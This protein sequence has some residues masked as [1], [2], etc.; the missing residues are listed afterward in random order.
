MRGA[1]LLAQTLSGAGTNRI[2]AL[3]GNQIMP[4]FDAC[5]DAGIKITHTRHEAAAVFMAEAY[6]QLTGEIGVV[7]VTAGGGLANTAGA[8]FSASESNTPVLLLSGDSP[9]AQDGRGAFQEL[10]Q[11]AITSAITKLSFRSMVAKDLGW[12]TARA[13]RAARS[14]RPG[15]VHIALPFDVLCEDVGSA[16][17]PEKDAFAQDAFAASNAAL[18]EVRERLAKSRRPLVLLGPAL[19]ATRAPALHATLTQALDA[20]VFAMESPRGLNDPSLGNL[21]E[22]F[23]AADLIISIDKRVDFTLGFGAGPANWIVVSA[24]VAELHR[25]EVNLGDRL[26]ETIHA[27]PRGFAETLASASFATRG[28]A[29]WRK[30]AAQSVAPWLPGEAVSGGGKLNSQEL[31]MAVRDYI[32][33]CDNTVA[34]CD[35]GEFGQWAQAATKGNARVING[36]SG[37]IG[38]GLPYAIGA[39]AA[40][41]DAT[42]FVLTGDGSVGFHF[43]E[44]E[45]AVRDGLP[46][47]LVIGNDQKWNAEHQIQLRDY[48]PERLTGCQLSPARYDLAAEALGAHGEFVSQR[49][50][51]AP[52]LHRARRSGKPACV[53]VL[54]D[55][56]PAPSPH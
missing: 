49:D 12:D 15:P 31:C 11:V 50:D 33:S 42:I 2:F 4:I 46:F 45:T 23:A 51:L 21:R 13:I 40:R 30:Y 26:L 29:A 18:A 35:G 32:G 39:K 5:L 44:F 41:P 36:I 37:A 22:L 19:N 28:R 14:G 48:G 6:A 53:N 47:V 56:L 52:A 55:G 25:A 7:L 9:I 24:N 54:V 17:L 43:A 16:V 27:C 38:G 1:D 10:D 8:L 3:S 34:I 20:P